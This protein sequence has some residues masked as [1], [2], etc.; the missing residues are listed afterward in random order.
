MVYQRTLGASCT[1]VFH[2]LGDPPHPHYSLFLLV[3][4]RQ[5]FSGR[6]CHLFLQ[7]GL[8]RLWFVW[9]LF[10]LVRRTLPVDRL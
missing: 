10:H 6:T 8:L 3:L 9:S 2:Q 1:A 4:G 7:V 5:W